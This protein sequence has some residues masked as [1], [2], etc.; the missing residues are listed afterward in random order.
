MRW[1]GNVARTREREREK[2]VLYRSLLGN[3]RERDHLKD[4]GVDRVIL[5]NS[6]FNKQDGRA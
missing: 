2:R 1:A 3:L 6:I 4:L 5:L